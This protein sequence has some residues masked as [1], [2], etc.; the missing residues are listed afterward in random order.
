MMKTLKLTAAMA[1]MAFTLAAPSAEAAKIRFEGPASYDLATRVKYRAKAPAQSGRYRTLGRGYYHA[2]TIGMRWIDNRSAKISGPLSFEFWALRFVGANS[3]PILSTSAVK[4]ISGFDS[5][6]DVRK[7]SYTL[8]I[9][10]FRFPDINIWERRDGRWNFR[11]AFTFRF[12]DH[13]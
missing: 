11:D 10:R 5:F 13:L 3:G 1:A 4:R 2:G 7:S 6:Y 9:D 8:Y 12:R